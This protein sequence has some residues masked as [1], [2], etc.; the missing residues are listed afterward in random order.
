MASWILDHNFE[1]SAEKVRAKAKAL[2]ISEADAYKLCVVEY[3]TGVPLNKVTQ[4]TRNAYNVYKL[5]GNRPNT[6]PNDEHV[7]KINYELQLSDAYARQR[8]ANLQLKADASV[9]ERMVV[10][11]GKEG[12]RRAMRSLEEHEKESSVF[13][14]GKLISLPD[15]SLPEWKLP[16]LKMPGFGLDKIGE[17][18]NELKRSLQTMGLVLMLFVAL[19][20]YLVFVKGKG[21]SGVN[22]TAVGK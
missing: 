21:A 4:Q 8:A 17:G 12:A 22:V 5:E 19:L 9:E 1:E 20:V 3:E 10:K 13:G 7:R 16:E 2:G 14:L 18:A 11:H 15:W 6:R